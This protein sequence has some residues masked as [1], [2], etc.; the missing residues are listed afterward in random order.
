[1]DGTDLFSSLL[2]DPAAL[3][4]AISMASSLLSGA[5]GG[6]APSAAPSGGAV[7]PAAPTGA[8]AFVPP[9]APGA[10]DAP[11][12]SGTLGASAPTYDPSADL[13]RAAMPVLGRIAKSAQSAVTPEKRN[14]LNAVKPF[15]GTHTAQQIDHGMKLVSLARM[16]SAAMNQLGGEEGGH[17]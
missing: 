12:G 4:S 5:A 3:Q 10:P 2:N 17:V 1:M 8:S 6:N 13:M 9:G 7:S 16:A 11:G 15:V 14:L